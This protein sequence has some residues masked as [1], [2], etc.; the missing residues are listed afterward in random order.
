MSAMQKYVS[1]KQR[2]V[3]LDIARGLAILFM[4]AQHSMLV[5]EVNEG[6]G[7]SILGN[8]FLLLGTAPAAPVFL[9][10]MGIFIANSKASTQR[11]IIRGIKIFL[12]GYVLNFAR[13]TVPLL[14][15]GALGS[16]YT[17]GETPLDY[18]LAVDILQ[19]A[20]LSMIFGALVKPYVE[21]K[22]IIPLII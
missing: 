20:G 5:H 14:I 19:L 1:Q 13:F 15:A 9:I 16:P 10:I 8:I 21:N 12:L 6:E 3:F 17:E 4:I 22:F 7:S 11:N 2:V 18:F